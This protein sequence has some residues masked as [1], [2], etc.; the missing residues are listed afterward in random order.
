MR[1]LLCIL[2]AVLS[3]ASVAS[4]QSAPQRASSDD[5]VEPGSTGNASVATVHAVLSAVMPRAGNLEP[6]KGLP[7]SA[8]QTTVHE[9]TLSDGT[10]IKSNVEIQ[11]WR[12]SEGRMRAESTL[13]TKDSGQQPSRIVAIW[14]P[15]DR[16][17][18]SWVS[19]TPAGNMP[20]MMHL[21]EVQIDGLIGPP[22]SPLPGAPT[23]NLRAVALPPDLSAQGLSSASVHT[24]V[25][26]GDSISGLEVTGTRTTRLIPAGSIGNDR[27]FIVTSESWI[28]PE[29]KTTLRQ[30]T[31]DPRTGTVSIEMSNIDRSEPAP[32]LF[33]PPAGYKLVDLQDSGAAD[34]GAKR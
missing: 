34:S 11:L 32:E 22:P 31:S 13:K 3:I 15:V 17:E 14:N 12:D 30:T 1:T 29:L 6:V 33:K 5:V 8:T 24:E 23:R 27:E 21:P 2:A 28:S 16:T 4:A 18:I 9:Q 19:G 10:V 7:F 25:L 20:T 26:P